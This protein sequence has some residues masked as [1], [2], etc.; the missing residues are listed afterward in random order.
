MVQDISAIDATDF[1]NEPNLGL[2]GVWLMNSAE[3]THQGRLK[4]L[5]EKQMALH[6]KLN[7][8]KDHLRRAYK[9]IKEDSKELADLSQYKQEIIQ[10]WNEWKEDLKNTDFEEY[11]NLKVDLDKLDFSKLSL[12][13]LS[14]ELI[15]E[16]EK[17]QNY[18]TLKYEKI[19]TELRMFI[20]LFTILVEILKE[21]PKKFAESNAH[22]NRNIGKG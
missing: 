17:I 5:E 1:R 4:R 16:L 19:P 10:L 14:D 11:K 15:P 3:N 13:H 22:I 2:E 20:E 6:H 8:L 12:S 7:A 9:P 21:L 18:H